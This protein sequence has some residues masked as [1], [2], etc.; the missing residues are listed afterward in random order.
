MSAG[1]PGPPGRAGVNGTVG[2]PGLC[3]NC[4]VSVPV[5]KTQRPPRGP[6]APPGA[7]PPPAVS[8]PPSPCS[9]CEQIKR[10]ADIIERSMGRPVAPTYSVLSVALA[11]L[12]P[13]MLGMLPSPE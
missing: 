2:A 13:C 1:P 10:L 5:T 11:P 6:T 3:G 9:T 8:K 12:V 4:S 7:S